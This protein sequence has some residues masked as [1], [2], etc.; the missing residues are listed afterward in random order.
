[1]TLTL[2]VITF[3]MLIFSLPTLAQGKAG[4]HLARLRTPRLNKDIK[5]VEGKVAEINEAKVVIENDHG[6][7]KELKV[8]AKTRF[9]LA[10]KKR[11]K[12]TEVKPG[13]FV[14]IT[15]S[16]KDLTATKVQ[17]TERK[18]REE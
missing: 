10:A 12:L 11:I 14:K 15:F 18:F 13:T 2:V 3:F 5:I 17:Q 1:M 6:A 8:S 16:E 7:R 4:D 9:H